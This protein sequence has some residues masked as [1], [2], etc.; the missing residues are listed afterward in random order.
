MER[1]LAS[2]IIPDWTFL[3]RLY[4]GHEELHHK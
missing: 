1:R 2:E 3:E 4:L